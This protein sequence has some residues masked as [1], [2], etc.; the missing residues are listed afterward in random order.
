M[1][2]G[3]DDVVVDVVVYGYCVVYNRAIYVVA[4]LN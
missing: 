2:L 1:K 3:P 4:L